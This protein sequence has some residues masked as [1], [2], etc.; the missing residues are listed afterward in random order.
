MMTYE[1]IK[2]RVRNMT[3]EQQ[4]ERLAELTKR[5]GITNPESL[6][7]RAEPEPISVDDWLE[8]DFLMRVLDLR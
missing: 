5:L 8:R 7:S 2:Q 1:E 6:P 4:E 3:R